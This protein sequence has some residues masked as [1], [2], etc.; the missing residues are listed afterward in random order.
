MEGKLRIVSG[1]LSTKL[2]SDGG[3][4]ILKPKHIR[5]SSAMHGANKVLKKIDLSKSPS[6]LKGGVKKLNVNVNVN[7]NGNR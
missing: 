4:P 5:A 1:N 7:V 3:T 6:P 2:N